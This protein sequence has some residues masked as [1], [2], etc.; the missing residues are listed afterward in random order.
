MYENVYG[1]D[2][3]VPI[4]SRDWRINFVRNS[5]K[6]R[7]PRCKAAFIEYNDD[8]LT[9]FPFSLSEWLG[10]LEFLESGPSVRDQ[11]AFLAKNQ[12]SQGHYLTS[13]EI[14]DE[15]DIVI[16]ENTSAGLGDLVSE[17][18]FETRVWTPEMIKSIIENGPLK[19]K[20]YWRLFYRKFPE[21]M[22]KNDLFTYIWSRD[23]MN[24]FDRDFITE[25]WIFD[26]EQLIIEIVGVKMPNLVQIDMISKLVTLMDRIEP[27]MMKRMLALNWPIYE[28]F[29]L[30]EKEKI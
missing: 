27:Y 23:S 10:M 2:A 30:E 25:N 13:I 6:F 7:M 3:Q 14:P 4:N 12:H 29:R 11:I 1:L 5:Q 18:M 15:F 9:D 26:L 20:W 19:L 24:P 17:K 28:M 16:K 22:D 21:F 8:N